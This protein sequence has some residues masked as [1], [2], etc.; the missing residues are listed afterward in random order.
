M[1][2]PLKSLLVPA[3]CASTFLGFSGEV[4]RAADVTAAPPPAPGQLVGYAHRMAG[5]SRPAFCS[6]RTARADGFNFGH[7]FTDKANRP[8]STKSS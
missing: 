2:R 3:L 4:G 8:C 6:I 5:S 7:L 1:S